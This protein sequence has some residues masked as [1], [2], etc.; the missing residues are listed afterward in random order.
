VLAALVAAVV[1]PVAAGA[2]GILARVSVGPTAKIAAGN[3][4]W[5]PV[6]YQCTSGT[7]FTIRFAVFQ[8]TVGAIARGQF[9]ATCSGNLQHGAAKLEQGGKQPKTFK[10][11]YARVCWIATIEEAPKAGLQRTDV[12]QGACNG[13]TIVPAG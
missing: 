3:G 7:F 4:V 9:H 12:M 13:V 1:T 11:G 2:P 5:M 8:A 10:P 6:R